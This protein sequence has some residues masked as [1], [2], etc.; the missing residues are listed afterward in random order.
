MTRNA[1]ACLSVILMLGLKE[2]V[3][4]TVVEGRDHL[5]SARNCNRDNDRPAH[6]IVAWSAYLQP[7]LSLLI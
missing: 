5:V 4:W 1:V 3:L 6:H 2:Y 7:E